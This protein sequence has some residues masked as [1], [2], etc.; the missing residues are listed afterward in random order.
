MELRSEDRRGSRGDQ[1]DGRYPAAVCKHGDL[2]QQYG[3]YDPGDGRSG[4]KEGGI[5]DEQARTTHAGE[6]DDLGGE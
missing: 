4:P 3:R 6:R 1:S 2:H 5:G